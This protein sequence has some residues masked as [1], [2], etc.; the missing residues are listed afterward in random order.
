MYVML[1]GTGNSW[2]DKVGCQQPQQRLCEVP[3]DLSVD[4]QKKRS[5]PVQKFRDGEQFGAQTIE[6]SLALYLRTAA[7][8]ASSNTFPRT[9]ITFAL[10]VNRQ[11]SRQTASDKFSPWHP[12]QGS[13]EESEKLATH[14]RH[15]SKSRPRHHNLEELLTRLLL[16][17][18]KTF[19]PSM[20][21][22]SGSP[23]QRHLNAPCSFPVQG[24]LRFNFGN[25]F[26]VVQ[27]VSVALQQMP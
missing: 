21:T 12:S 7:K 23:P 17:K 24:P 10:Q 6:N 14:A 1:R 5:Q 13:D 20:P 19:L 16:C 15:Q 26:D 18:S 2:L 9:S 3:G 4:V 25:C 8:I 22:T 27:S 11:R